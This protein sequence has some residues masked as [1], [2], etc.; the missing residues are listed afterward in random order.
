MAKRADAWLNRNVST[1]FLFVFGIVTIPTLLLHGHVVLKFFQVALFLLLC[2][3]AGK[4]LRIVWSLVFLVVIVSINGLSPTGRILAHIGSFPLTVGALS[5]GLDKGLTVVG[6]AYL[7]RFTVR[8]D[9]KLPTVLGQLLARTLYYFDRLCESRVRWSLKEPVDSLDRLMN[10]IQG[11]DVVQE[12]P[13]PARTS[14]WAVGG[15][16]FLSTLNWCCA[17]LA[18]LG[19][20]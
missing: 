6:L 17:L 18:Y 20:L 8:R 1:L 12:R 11:S 19:I 7:S 3:M 10:S 9:L 4:K 14:A 13:S 16:W 15:L 5:S 2:V